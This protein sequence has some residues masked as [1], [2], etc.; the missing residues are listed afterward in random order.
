MD[1]VWVQMEGPQILTQM[2]SAAL[3]DTQILGCIQGILIN[4]IFIII[5]FKI[6]DFSVCDFVSYLWIA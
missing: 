3:T 2:L 4:H 5:Q 1:R 6:Y